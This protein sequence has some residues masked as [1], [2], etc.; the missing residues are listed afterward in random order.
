[1]TDPMMTVKE[2]AT[3]LRV[4][5]RTV[6]RWVDLGRLRPVRVGALGH[7]RFRRSDVL[8]TLERVEWEEPRHDPSMG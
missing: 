4:E 7:I 8:R 2:V 1:M 5:P 6:R 3:L